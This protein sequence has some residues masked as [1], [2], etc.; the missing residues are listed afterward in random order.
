MSL[1][2][3]CQFWTDKFIESLQK[4]LMGKRVKLNAFGQ[5]ID[6]F[7]D[8]ANHKIVGVQIE[9]FQR[10]IIVGQIEDC[11][12]IQVQIQTLKGANTRWVNLN[13]N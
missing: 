13:L 9:L 8:N 6:H 7:D 12:A 2:Q 3:S 5:S 10:E 4:E 11:Y 1:Y